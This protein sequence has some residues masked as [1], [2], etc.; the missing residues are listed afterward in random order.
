MCIAAPSGGHAVELR[1]A[2][3]ALQKRG[4]SGEPADLVEWPVRRCSH[5]AWFDLIVPV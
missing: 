1:L 4:V 3:L 2:G 5:G